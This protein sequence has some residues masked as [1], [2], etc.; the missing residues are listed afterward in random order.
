MVLG[1]G[2]SRGIG[3]QW[4]W[5]QDNNVCALAS[6]ALWGLV[7]IIGAPH[8]DHPLTGFVGFGPAESGFKKKI[9]YYIVVSCYVVIKSKTY[10]C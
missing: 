4:H 5:G 1:T 7:F 2:L 9:F 6:V 3:Y 8:S 10:Y